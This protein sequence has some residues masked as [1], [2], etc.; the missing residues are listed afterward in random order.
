MGTGALGS[1]R[2]P[3][4][5]LEETTKWDIKWK[6]LRKNDLD[7]MGAERGCAKSP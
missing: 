5:T 7:G 4:R 6:E 2:D 3:E 1:S